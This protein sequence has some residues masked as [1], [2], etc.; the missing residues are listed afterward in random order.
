[1]I[2]RARSAKCELPFVATPL[3][4]DQLGA[5]GLCDYLFHSDLLPHQHQKMRKRLNCMIADGWGQFLHK[6]CARNAR[7][8]CL[9]F[10]TDT[11]KYRNIFPLSLS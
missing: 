5:S 1:M 2:S 11:I 7:A 4:D 3:P 10:R 8:D 6:L 9:A